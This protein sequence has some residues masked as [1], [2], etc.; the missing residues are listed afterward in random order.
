MKIS[1]SF[2][3]LL[4]VFALA[5]AGVFTSTQN[6]NAKTK[7]TK[8][9]P[10]A[11]RGD[12]R[13]KTMS[14][15]ISPFSGKE[16]YQ[17]WVFFSKNTFSWMVLPVDNPNTIVKVSYHHVKGSKNYYVRGTNDDVNIYDKLQLSGKKLRCRT[18]LTLNKKGHKTKTQFFC[19]NNYSH[20]L[21]KGQAEKR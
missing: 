16:T 12:W 21:Y 8:G 1:K 20:W 19:S 15:G 3:I 7:W 5:I 10:T 11:L 4:V 9:T 18:Y 6:A 13:A 14:T 2:K 17:Q